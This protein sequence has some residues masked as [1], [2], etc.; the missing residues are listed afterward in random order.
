MM[1]DGV[2]RLATCIRQSMYTA[3]YVYDFP[4]R[5]SKL[6]SRSLRVGNRELLHTTQFQDGIV[7]GIIYDLESGDSWA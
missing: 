5:S 3:I 7:Y 1:P 6:S 2:L 4:S